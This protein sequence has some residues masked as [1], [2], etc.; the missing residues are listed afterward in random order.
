MMLQLPPLKCEV[1]LKPIT[2]SFYSILMT[3]QV[4]I[5]SWMTALA[6]LHVIIASLMAVIINAFALGMAQ[7]KT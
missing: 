1:I 2:V 6:P 4:F 5:F 7:A 3:L